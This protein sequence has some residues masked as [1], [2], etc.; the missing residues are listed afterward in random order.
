MQAKGV[1]GDPAPISKSGAMT[2]SSEPGKAGAL[3][4]QI[5]STRAKKP[6]KD[7]NDSETKPIET[8][9]REV[10]DSLLPRDI[11]PR[12]E[13]PSWQV[14]ILRDE[15]RQLVGKLLPNGNKTNPRGLKLPL[16]HLIGKTDLDRLATI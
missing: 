5:R 3:G 16:K 9:K 2:K 15:H 13:V 11:P 4:T 7:G 6:R 14:A 1:R 10:A 12:H 8:A